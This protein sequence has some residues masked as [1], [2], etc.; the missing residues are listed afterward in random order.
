MCVCVCDSVCVCVTVCVCVA[1][2]VCAR[3]LYLDLLESCYMLSVH[4]LLIKLLTSDAILL[5]S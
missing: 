1:M 2:C 5:T 3:V 4:N